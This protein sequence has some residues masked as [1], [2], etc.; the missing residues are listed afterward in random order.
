MYFT[1]PACKEIWFVD[2]A[3]IGHSGH[4][5]SCG[6]PISI[7]EQTV[8]PSL[9]DNHAPP[10]LRTAARGLGV[11]LAWTLFLDCS[12]VFAPSIGLLNEAV[13]LNENS[14]TSRIALLIMLSA[15]VAPL[16]WALVIG[17]FVIWLTHVL[18]RDSAS[19]F[20]AC[21]R[22]ASLT[23]LC[24]SI[25]SMFFFAAPLIMFQPG[26]TTGR[27]HVGDIFDI[28]MKASLFGWVVGA[29]L[30][31]LRWWFR[32]W[33]RCTKVRYESPF[34]P[35]EAVLVSEALPRLTRRRERP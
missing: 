11:I 20:T 29:L 27:L 35:L 32:R 28:G 6:A 24:L 26:Y 8:S 12:Y 13:M 10:R 7:S 1:C 25:A 21:V 34:K 18:N 16:A 14:T 9:L 3:V 17:V 23:C 19:R 22:W 2:V 5:D 4:C 30:G 31:A 15:Y 33:I